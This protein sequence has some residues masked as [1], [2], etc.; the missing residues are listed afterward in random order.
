VE[1]DELKR[2]QAEVKKLRL[3]LASPAAGRQGPAKLDEQAKKTAEQFLKAMAKKDAGEAMKV[4]AFPFLQFSPTSPTPQRLTR[5]DLAALVPKIKNLPLDWK[6]ISSAT[7]T[8][9]KV[10]ADSK[11]TPNQL[12]PFD[13]ILKKSDRVVR[14]AFT[15]KGDFGETQSSSFLVMVTWRDGRAKVVGW[16]VPVFGGPLARELRPLQTW[17]G[18]LKDKKLEGKKPAGEV[19]VTEQ[20]F[21]ELW[22]AWRGKDDV[23]KVDFRRAFVVVL[24]DKFGSLGAQ[25]GIVEGGLSERM[26]SLG[27]GSKAEEGFSYLIAVFPRDGI[28]SFNGRAIPAK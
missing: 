10:I 20:T 8:W 13:G 26:R 16:T 25:F 3:C 27:S 6:K 11:F 14:F 24:T 4:V 23:P 18:A 15:E 5:E 9:E 17:N 28:K 2:L 19:L 1:Q 7:S 22:R 12:K 21:A